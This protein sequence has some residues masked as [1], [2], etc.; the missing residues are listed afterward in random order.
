MNW[1]ISFACSSA[2]AAERALWAEIRSRVGAFLYDCYRAGAF[3]EPTPS[4]AYF[5][6][7]D[8]GTTSDDDIELGIVNVLVGFKTSRQPDFLM[9]SLQL[10]AGQS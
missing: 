2:H 10:I 3:H 5:V 7:C 6:K 4:D 9:L 1:I 8:A